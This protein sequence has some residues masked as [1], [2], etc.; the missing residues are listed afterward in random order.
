MPNELVLVDKY[1]PNEVR[2]DYGVGKRLDFADEYHALEKGLKDA[3]KI[4]QH[5]SDAIAA[6]TI[7]GGSYE[8]YKKL[9]T[10][11]PVPQDLLKTKK[12]K[13]G[14]ALAA[15]ALGGY[16]MTPSKTKTAAGYTTPDA[17]MKDMYKQFFD[18]G[19]ERAYK[20]PILQ[21]APAAQKVIL[22]ALS[23]PNTAAH[24]RSNPKFIATTLGSAA[25]GAHM[26]LGKS[27]H[28]SMLTA[29]EI[30]TLRTGGS[31]DRTPTIKAQ[32]KEIVKPGKRG[33]LGRGKIPHIGLRLKAFATRNKAL[34]AIS[35]LVA[36]SGVAATYK[37]VK[38]LNDK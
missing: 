10:P 9:K 34:S 24:I 26:L 3:K 21:A 12:F 27:D 32:L 38:S 6:V 7:G 1:T 31:I 25:L 28:N 30:E 35:A 2:L 36:A 17:N 20:S 5:F 19:R 11:K 14:L 18:A 22:E 8:M 4:K 33:F 13:A 29:D 23:H 37:G 15:L 16:S